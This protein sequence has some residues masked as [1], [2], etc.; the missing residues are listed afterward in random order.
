M[1]KKIHFFN[2]DVAYQPKR[3]DSDLSPKMFLRE[4]GFKTFLREFGSL[5][6]LL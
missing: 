4:F 2:P 5:P 6:A 3:S 1:R